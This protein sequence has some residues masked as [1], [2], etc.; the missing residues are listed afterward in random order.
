MLAMTEMVIG[1]WDRKST[2]STIFYVFSYGLIFE[3]MCRSG[4]TIGNFDTK[5][6]GFAYFLQSFVR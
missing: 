3:Y 2:Y 5:T 4:V 1:K 6:R